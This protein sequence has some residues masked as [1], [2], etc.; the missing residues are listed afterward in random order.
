[1]NL[2]E[3]QHFSPQALSD[4]LRKGLA[5]FGVPEPMSL[6]EWA[7]R[8]FYLSA[9]SSYVEQGWRA[10]PFQRAIMACISNDDIREL[11]FIKSARVGYTKMLLASIGYYAHHKRRNQALWQPTDDDRDEFVKA[12]LDPMLRDVAVMRDVFP[13]YLSRHKDNTLQ[14]KKF[15]GSMCHLK[16]GKAAKNYRRISVDMAYLDEADAFD[17]DVENEGDPVT[18]AAKRIEGSTFPKLILGSTPKLRGFSLVEKRALACQ[19]TMDYHI[20]CPACHEWHPLTF[21]GKSKAHGFKWRDGDPETVR[22]LCPH[23]HCLIDH[24][25]YLAVW[26][27]GRWQTANGS[28]RLNHQGQFTNAEG[29]PAPAPASIA[30]RIWTAYSPNV[31]WASIVREFLEAQKLAKRG[32]VSKL[33]AFTNTTLGETWEDAS[34][35]SS[36]HELMARAERWLER[37][38]PQGGLVLTAGVDVQDN[39]FEIV[40]W[41]WGVGEESWPVDYM[42][43]SANPALESDWQK[44]A[45]YLQ[46]RFRHASGQRLGIEASAVDTG[47]HFTHHVYNF[48]REQQAKGRRV[49]AIK[50]DSKSGQPVKSHAKM[51]DINWRGRTIR[52]GIKLWHVGTDTAKDLI[53]GRLKVTQPG[54]GYIHFPAHFPVEFYEQLTAEVRVMQRTPTGEQYKWI[55]RSGGA[56]NEALD[57]TVYAIFAAHVLDLHRY[58]EKMWQRLS[59]AVQPSM[60]DLFAAPDPEDAAPLPQ[61]H[62]ID[63]PPARKPAST[64]TRQPVAQ[65][66]QPARQW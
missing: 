44:L 66:R 27:H 45:D 10:W 30:V 37:T 2:A 9:E 53:F 51:K 33:K 48:C 21:G 13:A 19:V 23:C 16:G 28:L 24:G 46:T 25:E 32:D 38:V 39:R 65:H 14:S 29:Q 63:P 57:C 52:N 54:P 60:P 35:Q 50:G 61:A 5:V 62:P 64:V 7:A 8:H 41:A 56:R 17:L 36:H 47:G 59:D 18:L 4:H 26:Q 11:V 49:F 58:T 42:V 20:A 34:E 3:V 15:L 12:E 1:M 22:H 31:G 6:D 40:V 43:I 55:K